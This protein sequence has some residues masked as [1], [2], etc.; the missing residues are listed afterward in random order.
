VEKFLAKNY[1]L[2]V[3]RQIVAARQG[4]SPLVWEGLA[5]L[6]LLGLSIPPEYGGFGGNGVHTMIVMEALG[7]HL[8]VEPYLSTVVLGASAIGLGGSESQRR[9]LL[10]KVVD[11]SMKLAFAHWEPRARYSLTQIETTARQEGAVWVINGRKSVVLQGAA[12]DL[13]VVSAR[14]S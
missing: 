9:I 3:R 14:T 12:A 5:S 6:G 1:S 8:V 2:E 11:G 4:M 10:P 7:R 13:L